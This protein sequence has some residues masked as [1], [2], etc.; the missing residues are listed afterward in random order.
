MTV[1]AFSLHHSRRMFWPYRPVQPAAAPM[2]V[3][4]TQTGHLISAALLY[5]FGSEYGDDWVLAAN[6]MRWLKVEAESKSS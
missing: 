5:D 3:A 2:T 6:I 4:E 1:D